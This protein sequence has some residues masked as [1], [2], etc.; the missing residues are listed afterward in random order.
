M[1]RIQESYAPIAQQGHRKEQRAKRA[2][3]VINKVIP[4]LL[5]SNARARKGVANAELI[6]RPLHH[7]ATRYKTKR[8]YAHEDTKQERQKNGRRSKREPEINDDIER[9]QK[10]F[11]KAENFKSSEASVRISMCE[12]LHAARMLD[13]SN[14]KR[15]RNVAIL[16]M[17]SP[18]RPGGGVLS[19]A[20][21]QE[22]KLCTRTT[23][24]PSLK[25]EWYRL[26]ELGGIWT[27]EVLVF[28]EKPDE[29][30]E[31]FHVDVLTSAMIRLPDVTEEPPTRA[32]LKDD[33]APSEK[34]YANH[35]DSILALSKIRTMLEILQSKGVEYVVLG[36]WGCGAYGN[37]VGEVVRAYKNAL[38][39]KSWKKESNSSMNGSL[40]SE[41]SS[42]KEIVFAIND[43]KMAAN[44]AQ[45]WGNDIEVTRP[46]TKSQKDA[47]SL[48]DGRDVIEY[49][50]QQE[51][52]EKIAE[53]E[54]QIERAQMPHLRERLESIVT[55]LRAQLR[56][57]HL[58][59]SRTAS[60]A[61]DEDDGIQGS[62]RRGLQD[63]S[64]NS[65]EE[66]DTDELED[67]GEDESD[68]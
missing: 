16:N 60:I 5:I 25:E 22:E 18:L 41:W 11:S 37:P 44:F 45:A 63:Y 64:Q 9:G 46:P 61:T 15:R 3:F 8:Q 31:H 53:L 49:R 35:A 48:G 67:S 24:L 21:S 50:E 58:P 59:K 14:F 29:K 43:P 65:G 32:K 30:S 10:Q 62:S 68:D 20:N 54:L 26:P 52:K 33:D 47:T 1:G 34:Y 51:I 2:K 36:A 55:K 4:Q 6:I 17:A 7:D 66:V 40:S 38:Y 39:G 42:F 56:T 23:L 13:Q 28:D 12:T 19:G 27:P 57:N